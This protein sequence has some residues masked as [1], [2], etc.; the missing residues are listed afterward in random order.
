MHIALATILLHSGRAQE[1]RPFTIR[2][3]SGC[4][5]NRMGKCLCIDRDVALDPRHS[6]SCI[7]ALR[8]NAIR[9]FLHLQHAAEYFI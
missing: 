1:E 9:V 8:M 5:G 3:L 6:L 2:Y 7:A 4:D